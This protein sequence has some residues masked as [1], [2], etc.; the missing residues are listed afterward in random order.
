MKMIT[1]FFNK[2]LSLIRI[3]V[4]N[5]SKESA[6]RVQSYFMLILVMMMSLSF[7]GIE[8][9][10]FIMNPSTYVISSEIII[11]FSMILAHHLGILYQ[12]RQEMKLQNGFDEKV[13][14]LY[15][16]KFGVKP[17]SH[18]ATTPV[19][20][21]TPVVTPPVDMNSGNNLPIQ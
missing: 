12:K 15:E 16:E 8:I 1:V 13:N 14:S 6:N 17:S 18:V 19:T 11:I 9:T 3:S 7:L 5:N 20:P 4:D 10:R 2:I 21:T